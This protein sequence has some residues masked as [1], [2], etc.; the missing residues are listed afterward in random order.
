MSV[1]EGRK[2]RCGWIGIWGGGMWFVLHFISSHPLLLLLSQ[3]G[4]FTN[5]TTLKLAQKGM[6]REAIGVI[7]VRFRRG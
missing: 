5:K 1:E 3:D 7:E 4:R 6:K 2:G